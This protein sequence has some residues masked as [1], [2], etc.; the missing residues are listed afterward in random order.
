MHLCFNWSGQTA[1][2]DEVKT[3]F[4]E[5][6]PTFTLKLVDDCPN[7]YLLDSLP[8]E[9]DLL[10]SEAFGH[11]I[12]RVGLDEKYRHRKI[13]FFYERPSG[14]TPTTLTLVEALAPATLVSQ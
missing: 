11:F 3:R 13:R 10:V 1:T 12:E 14:D 5:P 9:V 2:L 6:D 8:E 4:G 7:G